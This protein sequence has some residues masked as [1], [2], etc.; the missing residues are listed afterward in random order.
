MCDLFAACFSS[1]YRAPKTL[2]KFML[3]S[4]ERRDV[5]GW[6]VGFFLRNKQA[7][8]VK[9]TDIEI[10]GENIVTSFD[11]AI[12]CIESEIIVGHFRLASRGDLYGEKYAHPFKDVFLDNEWIF[13]HNGYSESIL[14]YRTRGR[15][16][17][18]DPQFDSP[19]IFEYIRD[20]MVEY[21]RRRP[22]GSIFGAT[23]YAVRKLYEE[24]GDGTYNFVLANSNVVLINLDGRHPHNNKMFLLRREKAQPYEKAA[25]ITTIPNLTSESWITIKVGRG[26]RGKLLMFSEG[27]LLYNGDI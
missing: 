5:D 11:L 27:E 18:D 15:I 1:E 4:I 2:H 10:R 7:V 23:R 22:L 26:Y 8:V 16:I 9:D 6:G 12:R 3:R 24:F 14:R 20:R 25:I 17:H 19:R 13:A 21:F